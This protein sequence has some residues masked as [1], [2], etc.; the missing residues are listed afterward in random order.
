VSLP[1]NTVTRRRASSRSIS[2]LRLSDVQSTS[3]SG[4]HR[5]VLTTSGRT[6][7]ALGDDVV[8]GERL[9]AGRAALICSRRKSR[10]SSSTCGVGVVDAGVGRA[11][12]RAHG[13]S[14][15]R[16]RA[17]RVVEE[18][19]H[20][21]VTRGG[22]PRHHQVDALGVD[23]AVIGR[24]APTRV[25]LVDERAGRVD[26]RARRRGELLTRV[27]VAQAERRPPV[28]LALGARRARRSWPPP[29]RPRSPSGRRRTRTGSRC[30]SGRRPGTRCRRAR[31]SVSMT[32]SRP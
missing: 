5:S 30:R 18:R 25:E 21:V 16:R 2:C 1:P 29:P 4:R 28:A 13:P 9:R 11:D 24:D 22:E 8:V 7:R 10:S 32:G 31:C 6:P 3:W 20:P 15:S 19:E 17:A 27:D 26:D 14:G 23:D 12:H